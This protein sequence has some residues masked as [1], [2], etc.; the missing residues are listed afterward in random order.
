MR[1][2]IATYMK[3][4]GMPLES[5]QEFLGH[6]SPQMTRQVYAMTWSEVMDEQVKEYRPARS[7]SADRAESKVPK[8]V[9]V[10]V[11]CE[12]VKPRH[13]E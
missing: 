3:S 6:S 4:Q 1:R 10:E 12:G 7:E 11:W 8:M 9:R 5:V 2:Y 13:E